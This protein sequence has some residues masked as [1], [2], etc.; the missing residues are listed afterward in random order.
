MSA[1]FRR[2]TMLAAAF[3]AVLWGVAF[4]CYLAPG[5][6]ARTTTSGYTLF[7]A[8]CSLVGFSLSLMVFAALRGALRLSRGPRLALAAGAITAALAAHAVA[9]TAS[10]AVLVHPPVARPAAALSAAGQLLLLNGLLLAPVH[11]AFAAGLALA[12]SIRAI[13]ERERRLTAALAAVQQAQ[14]AA[15]RFQINPHFLF[16]AL[17]AVSA[18]VASRRNDEADTVVARLADFFRAS[19]ERPPTALVTLEEEFDIAGSYLDIEAT[20]FGERLLVEI[21][22]PRGLATALTPHFL[23]QP[24]VENAV[25]HAVAHSKR[26]VTIRV[27]AAQLDRNLLIEVRDNGPPGPAAGGTGVGLQNVRERLATLYGEAARF[28]T[29]KLEMGFLA[30]IIVPLSFAKTES[31]VA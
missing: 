21:E 1:L 14:L 13:H 8:I 24:L 2:H 4:V 10:F 17:N 11:L 26:P 22:L 16:N 19:I 7:L 29:R 28:E 30:R 3:A 25:K 31:R 6:A 9:D 15:L 27:M 18:L 5:V 20:R 23:L 12:F